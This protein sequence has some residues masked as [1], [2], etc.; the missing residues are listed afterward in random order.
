MFARERTLSVPFIKP[1]RIERSVAF[2]DFKVN[3]VQDQV[4]ETLSFFLFLV[5]FLKTLLSIRVYQ[6]PEIK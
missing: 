6:R 1:A 5:F 3:K 2:P 4:D